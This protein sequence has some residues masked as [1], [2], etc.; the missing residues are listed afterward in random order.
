M[1]RDE[2]ESRR[3]P[4]YAPDQLIQGLARAKGA[5]QAGTMP[6]C[7]CTVPDLGPDLGLVL[8]LTSVFDLGLVQY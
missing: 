7:P 3:G 4:V 8:Y 2:T 1:Y 5:G 6:A